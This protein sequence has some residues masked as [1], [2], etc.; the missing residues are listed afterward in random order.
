MDTTHSTKATKRAFDLQPGEV[1]W[2]DNHDV[3]H[4]VELVQESELG[5]YVA[6]YFEDEYYQEFSPGVR[7]EVWVPGTVSGRPSPGLARST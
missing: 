1:L 6:V 4:V 2:D 3:Y 5:S 7:C